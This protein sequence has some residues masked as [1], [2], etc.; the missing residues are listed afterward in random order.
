MYTLMLQ[1]YILLT[2]DETEDI[3]ESWDNFDNS[4]L[5][6]DSLLDQNVASSSPVTPQTG[7]KK[8]V[9]SIYITLN[10]S[11]IKYIMS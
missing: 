6:K 5:Y 9:R 7:T 8:E 2:Q 3:N 4:N 11:L 1:V 10:F